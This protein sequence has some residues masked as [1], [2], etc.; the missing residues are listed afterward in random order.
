MFSSIFSSTYKDT[1]KSC[2]IKL[3]WA[4]ALNYVI[5]TIAPFSLSI[6]E[7]KYNVICDNKKLK[8]K[9]KMAIKNKK[10]A[11]LMIWGAPGIGKTSIL[12]SVLEEMKSDSPDY[13]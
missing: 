8:A 1:K 9:V 5:V 12:M 11:R 4:A 3:Y 13:Q 10:L 2:T 7:A 6:P